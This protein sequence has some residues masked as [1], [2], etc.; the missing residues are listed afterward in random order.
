MIGG[1]SQGRLI[2]PAEREQVSNL[3]PDAAIA[4]LA[5]RQHGVVGRD[6]LLRA[7]LSSSAIGRR[8]AAGKLH[9]LYRGGY[10]VGHEVVS[11]SGRW[12]GATLATGGVLSHRSAGALWASALGTA[13]PRSRPGGCGPS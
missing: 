5:G 8:V 13:E 2:C 3:A 11:L 4:D 7:G 9:P 6:Q 12:M 1:V 10:A